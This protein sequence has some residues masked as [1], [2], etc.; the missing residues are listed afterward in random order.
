VQGPDPQEA[1]S[2]TGYVPIPAVQEGYSSIS[3]CE[4]VEAVCLALAMKHG[5]K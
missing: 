2:E 4:S 5:W 1:L 3:V